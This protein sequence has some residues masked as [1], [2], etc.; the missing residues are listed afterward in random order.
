MQKKN[1]VT[2]PLNGTAVTVWFI[3][4]T[5][6]DWVKSIQLESRE[7]NL[8]VSIQQADQLVRMLVDEWV[9]SEEEAAYVQNCGCGQSHLH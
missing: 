9:F 4:P 1:M 2:L 8:A 6:P 3:A 7:P 5:N